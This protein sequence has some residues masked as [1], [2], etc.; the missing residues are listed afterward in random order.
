MDQ[1]K[2]CGANVALMRGQERCGEWIRWGWVGL[3]KTC[4]MSDA[5]ALSA[6]YIF[7]TER[8]RKG[9][10]AT[11]L[12]PWPAL[13]YERLQGVMWRKGKMVVERKKG[14][15]SSQVSQSVRRS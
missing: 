5:S 13:N 15:R 4:A 7:V 2:E 14:E 9:K 11:C 8:T 1:D 3:Y 10:R 12:R 6:G